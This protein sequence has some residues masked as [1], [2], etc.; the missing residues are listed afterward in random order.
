VTY[1]LC[2]SGLAAC[3][4]KRSA[5]S[6]KGLRTWLGLLLHSTGPS[7]VSRSDDPVAHRVVNKL[8]Q[9]M[10]SKLKHNLS[11]VCLSGTDGD[12]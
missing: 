7:I 10:E 5:G 3:L 1:S 6:Q 4:R 8:G 11:P 12:S 9:R 2:P